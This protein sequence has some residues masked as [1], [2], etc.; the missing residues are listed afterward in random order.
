MK[1]FNGGFLDVFFKLHFKFFFKKLIN[2]NKKNIFI[3][4]LDYNFNP[5]KFIII[6]FKFII[7]YLKIIENFGE[8]KLLK[9]L[10]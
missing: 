3:N 1:L 7:N 10:I 2:K 9:Y 4:Y 6:N 5:N 8:F